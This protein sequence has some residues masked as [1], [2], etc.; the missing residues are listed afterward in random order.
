[1]F[2]VQSPQQFAH[3]WH[4]AVGTVPP[5]TGAPNTAAP[6]PGAVG[7]PVDAHSHLLHARLD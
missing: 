5:D 2:V 1:M 4:R 3:R 7:A 6:G